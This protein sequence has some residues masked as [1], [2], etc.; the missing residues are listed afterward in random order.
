MRHWDPLPYITG[1]TLS[2][3]RAERLAA[4]FFTSA[5]PAGTKVDADFDIDIEA[6]NLTF[7]MLLAVACVGQPVTVVCT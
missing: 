5:R 1:P 2:E 6:K 4:Q 7:L 3:A